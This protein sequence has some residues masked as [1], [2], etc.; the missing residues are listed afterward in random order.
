[1]STEG[2]TV[3]VAKYWQFT[4]IGKRYTEYFLHCSFNFSVA[5]KFFK[6]Q[7]GGNVQINH[8]HT[9]K[10]SLFNRAWNRVG[11]ARPLWCKI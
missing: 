2:Q 5:L 11:K 1:M 6:I 7:L 3:S 4:K 9:G 10:T 8:G